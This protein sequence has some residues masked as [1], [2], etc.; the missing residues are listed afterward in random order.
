LLAAPVGVYYRTTQL[1]VGNRET[2]DERVLCL[3]RSVPQHAAKSSFAESHR[4]EEDCLLDSR[5]KMEQV[6]ELSHASSGDAEEAAP[7]ERSP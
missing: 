5:R 6:E 1:R 4:A 2:G 7:P 3:P